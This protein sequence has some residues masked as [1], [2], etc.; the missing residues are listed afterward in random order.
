MLNSG[1]LLKFAYGSLCSFC[2]HLSFSM[3][4]AD[5]QSF[6]FHM[7]EHFM[8]KFGNPIAFTEFRCEFGLWGVVI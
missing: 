4:V 3:C 1:V 6:P 7:L 5:S 8:W 2:E